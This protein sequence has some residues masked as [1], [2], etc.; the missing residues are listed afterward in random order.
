MANLSPAFRSHLQKLVRS[1]E[2]MARPSTP[3]AAANA[4][5]AAAA[6]SRPGTGHQTS[7]YKY[8]IQ[9]ERDN[10]KR[11]DGRINNQ[12][13]KTYYELI[14]K[15]RNICKCKCICM[16]ICICIHIYIYGYS[17]FKSF[18]SVLCVYIHMC[19]YVNVC[20]DVC[21]SVC[22]MQPLAGDSVFSS[23]C[24]QV[25]HHGPG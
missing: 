2:L 16:H 13:N 23:L 17:I 6:T 8:N 10:D 22:G 5:R 20:I 18:L 14:R 19:I 3:K 12:T 9:A 7:I 15:K 25:S 1:K 21:L 11:T 4:A 24:S